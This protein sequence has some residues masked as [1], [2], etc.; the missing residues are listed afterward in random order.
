MELGSLAFRDRLTNGPQFG[1]Y[2]RKGRVVESLRPTP[3]SYGLKDDKS[4]R[5]LRKITVSRNLIGCFAVPNLSPV[6]S[7]TGVL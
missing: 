1:Q 6:I 4:Q 2:R 7:S 5:Y 3:E